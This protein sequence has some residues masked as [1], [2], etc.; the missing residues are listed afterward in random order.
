MSKPIL[1]TL[2][3]TF[4]SAISYAED[5]IREVVYPDREGV[6]EQLHYP[7]ALLELALKNSGKPFRLKQS[8]TTMNDARVRSH[9]QKGQISV[10]WFGTSKDFE[11]LF[12]PVR[13][14]VTRGTLGY[15]LFIIHRDNE[16]SFEK[17]NDL[18]DLSKFIAGQGPGWAD[19]AILEHAG[20]PVYST[21]LEN[22]FHMIAKKRIA[23]LPLGANEVFTMLK[24]RSEQFPELI[25]ERNLTLIYPFDFLF[26]VN[27]KDRELRDMIYSGLVTAFENGEYQTLFLEHPDNQN[28]ASYAKIEGRKQFRIDNPLITQETAKALETYSY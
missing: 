16:K 24:V 15:R 21:D 19:I 6:K 26:F 22:I 3:L 10:A 12:L 13:V 7:Y 20:L 11:S 5:R 14:P 18:K 4:L 2:L 28:F 27:K 8:I 23:Y 1:Y 17:I 9:L 25:V